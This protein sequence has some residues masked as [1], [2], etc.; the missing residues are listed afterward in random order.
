MHLYRTIA[1]SFIA[2]ADL[3]GV[4]DETEI[5]ALELQATIGYEQLTNFLSTV[6]SIGTESDGLVDLL[7]SRLVAD[8]PRLQDLELENMWLPFLRHLIPILVS[9]N[10]PLDTA[11]YQQLFSTLLKAYLDTYVQRE[12]TSDRTLARTGVRCSCV[13]CAR[14]NDFLTNPALTVQSFAVNQ[15]RRQHLAQSLGASN[16]DCTHTTLQSGSPYSL[17]VTKTF[18][19]HKEKHQDWAWRR[20]TAAEQFQQFDQEHLRKLLG[21][22]YSSIVNMEQTKALRVATTRQP[23]QPRENTGQ[24]LNSSTRPMNGKKRKLPP[25]ESEVVDLTSE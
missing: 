10:I 4:Y 2:S 8:A 25:T 12:P 13:D 6:I 16:V 22:D 14:L 24:S 15:H 23:R 19:H 21:S 5:Q 7:I 3:T 1:R 18:R 9:K 20:N 17:V 11:C